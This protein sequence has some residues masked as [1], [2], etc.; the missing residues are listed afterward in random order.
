MYKNERN[1]DDIKRLILHA[2]AF[3]ILSVKR[4]HS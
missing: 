3:E 2:A 1:I 4:F